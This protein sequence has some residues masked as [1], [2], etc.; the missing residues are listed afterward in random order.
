[1]VRLSVRNF[2]PL[3]NCEIYLKK[4]NI[5]IGPQGSGKSTIVFRQQKWIGSPKIMDNVSA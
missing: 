5:F 1:M 3:K 4:I 2:G